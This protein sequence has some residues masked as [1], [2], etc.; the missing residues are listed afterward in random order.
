MKN[1]IKILVVLVLTLFFNCEADDPAP[2]SPP[3]LS[4]NSFSISSVQ[5]DTDQAYLLL[6]D[7]PQYNDGFG[8]VFINGNMIE[9]NVNGASVETTT[10]QGAVL[11][12]EFSNTDV[13]SEQAVTNQIINNSN[14][15]LDR[16]TS[17]IT[18][19]TNY[20][21]T[22]VDNGVQYGEPDET[23]A[24]IY[25]IGLTGNGSINIISFTVDLVTRTGNIDCSYT[26]LDENN[27]TVSGVFTGSFGIINEF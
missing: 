20:T 17:A 23:N 15:N 12:V 9:D 14:F 24:T 22:F 18:N 2:L 1:L 16:E 21:D 13:T 26:F 19:I 25:E 11:W 6:D 10:T 7:G 8:L 4:T 3:P 5:Y 27:N